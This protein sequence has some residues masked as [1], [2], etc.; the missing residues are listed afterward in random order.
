[1]SDSGALLLLDGGG[2]IGPVIA[3]RAME[4]ALERARQFGVSFVVV[5]NSNHFGI[6]AYYAE[7]SL[8]QE[9]VGAA[10]TNAGPALAAWGGKSRVIGSNVIAI[11]VPAGEERPVV[12]DAAI[13]AAAGA[14]IFLA[15][16]RGE[17]I[18]S[19]WMLDRDG[20]PT[21][22][23]KALLNGG[24]ILPFGKHK[25][26]GLGVL[27][28]VLTGVISGGLFSNYVGQFA[29]DM[30]RPLGVCHSFAALDIRRFISI[31]QFKNRMD[32]M[33][34]N[35]KK[36]EK[37]EGVDRIY[38][39]GERGLLTSE[40]RRRN[41]IPLHSKLITDL[42]RLGQRLSVSVPF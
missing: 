15:G 16:E 34:R 28:D 23:P 17:R 3:N 29:Q 40:D 24:V 27:V 4:L 36:S 11:A 9:M 1:V 31:D 20:S 39:P 10:F 6:G 25:G 35:V 12:F 5:R 26:Y 13:G 41:G 33:I 8:A 38:L 18:P 37:R 32:E 42:R 22:D 30:S 19:D 21:D 14:K 2:G 7:K